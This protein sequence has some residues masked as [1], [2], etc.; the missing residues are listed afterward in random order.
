MAFNITL[1]KKLNVIE[2]NALV[3]KVLKDSRFKQEL[4]DKGYINE[5]VDELDSIDHSHPIKQKGT[6]WAENYELFEL[7]ANAIKTANPGMNGVDFTNFTFKRGEDSFINR[8]G[9]LR[10]KGDKIE[11]IIEMVISPVPEISRRYNEDS[12]HFK[13]NLTAPDLNAVVAEAITI[14]NISELTWE[15]YDKVNQVLTGFCNNSK[16]VKVESNLENENSK[17]LHL[18]YCDYDL[19]FDVGHLYSIDMDYNRELDGIPVLSFHFTRADVENKETIV[20]TNPNIN[21]NKDPLL[22]NNL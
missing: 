8:Y 6:R 4:I 20:L 9:N 19:D 3:K 17:Y 10:Q 13:F 14:E 15:D 22:T 18:V 5:N 11:P 16:T 21:V 12:K 7:I 2:Q 1:N